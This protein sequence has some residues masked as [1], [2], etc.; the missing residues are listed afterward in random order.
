MPDGTIVGPL[1]KFASMG[2]AL[3]FPVEAMYF[4]TCCVL[5]LLKRHNLP[6]SRS[7]ILHVRRLLYVYGDDIIVPSTDAV[8]VLDYLQRYNCKVNA[9]KSFWTGKFRESCGVDAYDG[10]VVSPTYIGTL[11]PK[12]KRQPERLISWT[13]TANLFYKRGYWR[14][15]QLLFNYVEAVLGPLPYL[16]ETSPG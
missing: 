13:A 4:Y 3:C 12:N 10:K 16:S 11:P 5:A 7:N 15:A 9:T 1:E 6:V 2:S 14:T 8:F